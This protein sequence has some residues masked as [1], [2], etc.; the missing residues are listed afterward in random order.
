MG[1]RDN[2]YTATQVAEIFTVSR[3]TVYRWKQLGK[4]PYETI[5]NI[6]LFPKPI[7]ESLVNKIRCP[8]CGGL[9]PFK[10]GKG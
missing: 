6:V 1:I 5:G 7:V 10:G 3:M 2:Y 8:E 4:L 9:K